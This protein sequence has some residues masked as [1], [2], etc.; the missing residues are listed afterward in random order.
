[1]DASAGQETRCEGEER[2]PSPRHRRGEGWGEGS[3]TCTIQPLGARARPPAARHGIAWSSPLAYN[4]GSGGVR[5][6]T[7]SILMSPLHRRRTAESSVFA[8]LFSTFLLSAARADEPGFKS[9]LQREGSDRLAAGQ[10]RAGRQDGLRRRPVRGQG[11]RPRDHRLEG[12]APQDGRDR[13]GGIVS[14]ATSPSAWNSAP[15]GTR[16]AACTCATRP[17][18][19][20]SRSATTPGSARTRRSRATRTATGTR[21]R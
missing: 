16:T 11:R 5:P 6:F 8:L 3:P 15:P 4:Q 21:S 14:T 10:R 17:S 20:S 18:R 9:H 19:I 1:M 13:H 7:G 12:H 2:S